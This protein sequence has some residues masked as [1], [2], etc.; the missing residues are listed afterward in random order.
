MKIAIIL[1]RGESKRIPNKN[2]K[3]FNGKPMIY[4]P[5]T[6]AKKSKI[7]DNIIVSTDSKKI[8]K[9]AEKYGAEVPFLRNKNLSNDF[10]GTTKVVSN[11]VRWLNKKYQKPKT[12]CCV[13]ACAPFIKSDDI[14]D[15][16][17]KLK[18]GN[19]DYVFSA[20]LFNQEVLRSFS[21]NKKGGVNTLFKNNYNK[22]TQDLKKNIAYDAGQFYWAKDNTWEKCKKIFSLSSSVIL[23]PNWRSIDIN[24]EYD[25]KFALK[26]NKLNKII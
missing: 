3:N 18:A 16:Y 10:T 23:I 8:A 5:I 14:N 17:K 11:M 12:I 4:W 24:T 1:A 26:L 9:I 13:Y 25:W 21:F 15:A 19:W 6:A 22:R 20:S 2:I 7:F